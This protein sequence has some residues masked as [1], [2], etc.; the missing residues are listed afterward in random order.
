MSSYPTAAKLLKMDYFEVKRLLEAAESQLEAAEKLVDK[1]AMKMGY[2][3]S[4][5]PPS[6]VRKLVVHCQRMRRWR[7]RV[8]MLDADLTR[9]DGGT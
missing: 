7:L 8:Q 5:P 2:P 1:Y 4:H 6:D 9:R 3:Q